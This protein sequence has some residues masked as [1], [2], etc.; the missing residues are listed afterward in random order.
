LEIFVAGEVG[1]I[2]WIAG[3]QIV[4]RDH[5]MTFREQSIGQ[6]RTEEASATGDD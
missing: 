3:N 4:D 1:D 2:C 6:M 5:T